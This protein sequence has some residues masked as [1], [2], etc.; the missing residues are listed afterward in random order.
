MMFDNFHHQSNALL[1]WRVWK[2]NQSCMW[3]VVQVYQFPEVR[4]NGNQDT[5]I[6][7]REFQ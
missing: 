4:I 7:F 5:I 1:R 3:N 2:S 6:G